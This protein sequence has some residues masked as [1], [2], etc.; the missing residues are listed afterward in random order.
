MDDA[1]PVTEQAVQT[2]RA[3]GDTAVESSALTIL[4]CD[5]RARGNGAAAIELARQAI[6]ISGGLNDPL[7]LYGQYSGLSATLDQAGMYEEAIQILR[8]GIERIDAIGGFTGYLFDNLAVTLTELGRYDEAADASARQRN[9][10]CRAPGRTI[11][12]DSRV[13]TSRSPAGISSPPGRNLTPRAPFRS[14]SPT[15]T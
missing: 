8:V 5:P 7:E 9:K 1:L 4:G 11:I 12:S 15:C 13:P 2:A 10:R 3:I 14:A 6:A